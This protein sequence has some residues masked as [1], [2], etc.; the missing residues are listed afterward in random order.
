MCTAEANAFSSVAVRLLR[1][2]TVRIAV[3]AS[4]WPGGATDRLRSS[5]VFNHNDQYCDLTKFQV[6][7]QNIS[8]VFRFPVDKTLI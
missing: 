6:Y 1:S 7:F 5:V 2:A 8:A 4:F 3:T